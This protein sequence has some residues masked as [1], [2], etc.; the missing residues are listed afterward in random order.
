ML[1]TK[2]ERR[3]QRE[4]SPIESEAFSDF[5]TVDWSIDL[6]S[7]AFSPPIV[8]QIPS[9]RGILLSYSPSLSYKMADIGD[10]PALTTANMELQNIGGLR[11]RQPFVNNLWGK[12][13]II[14]AE[15]D[16]QQ[17]SRLCDSEILEQDSRQ[18]GTG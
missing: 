2:S 4:E 16:S 10:L 17:H 11:A 9:L 8:S 18:L 3:I 6:F 7:P 15:A 14:I 1:Q 12:E 5:S 13:L